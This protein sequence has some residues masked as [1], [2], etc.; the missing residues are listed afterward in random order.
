MLQIV[1]CLTSNSKRGG[2]FFLSAS[3]FNEE[4]FISELFTHPQIS[5]FRNIEPFIAILGAANGVTGEELVASMLTHTIA[6]FIHTLNAQY[7]IVM[8]EH[9]VGIGILFN[10]ARNV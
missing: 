7:A 6:L 4:F 10:A 5:L 8:I 2:L 3:H 1:R 9:G